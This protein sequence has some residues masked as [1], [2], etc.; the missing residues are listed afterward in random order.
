MTP[1]D[2]ADLLLRLV[3]G[4]GVRYGHERSV[5]LAPGR[6]EPHRFLLTLSKSSLGPQ[7]HERVLGVAHQLGPPPEFCAA[8]ED[9]LPAAR[10]VHFGFE[11]G[12]TACLS[13]VYLEFPPTP[14]AVERGEP[15]LQ[16]R[17]FKWDAASPAR[18]AESRYVWRPGLSIEAITGEVAG[19][20]PGPERATA[21]ALAEAILRLAAGLASAEVLRYVEVREENS[22][23]LSFDLNVYRAGLR[24]ADVGEALERLFRHYGLPLAWL[25]KLT[26]AIGPFRLGHLAGGTHRDGSEFFTIYYGAH[27]VEG[28]P[29]PE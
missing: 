13:K 17:G 22:P 25:A 5:R 14:G 2:R 15:V 26:E 12:A 1:A 7:A 20:F 24:V 18:R 28:R 9:A 21:R 29:A 3:D 23:R 4:L 11:A 10:F 27:G 6:I 8:I 19:I 16:F